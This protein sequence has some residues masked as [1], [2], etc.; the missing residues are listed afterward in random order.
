MPGPA[1]TEDNTGGSREV[2][3]V[4]WTTKRLKLFGP[5]PYSSKTSLP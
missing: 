3:G 2:W 5:V 4:P 1:V